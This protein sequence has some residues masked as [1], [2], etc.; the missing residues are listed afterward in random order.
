MSAGSRGQ[1][2]VIGVAL[3][4]GFV[5]VGTFAVVALGDAALT[6]TQ[7][8]SE[9]ARAEQSMTL[10]DSQAA[11][12]ALGDSD[13]QTVNLGRSDASYSIDSNA[14][15]ISI[16]QLDCD[17]NDTNDDGDDEAG[18]AP[19][20]DLTTDDDAYIMNPTSLGALIYNTDDGELAYQGGGVWRTSEGGGSVMVSPPEFHY[21][22]ATL[23]LPV[24]LTRGSGGGSGSV[25]TRI[26]S[27]TRAI[28]IFPDSA[29]G[30]PDRCWEDGEEPFQ[31]PISDGEVIV[32]IQSRYYEA[33][34]R[35]F[36]TRTDGQVTYDHDSEIV[37]VE[38]ISLGQVGQFQ[39][40][41][42]GGSVTVTGASG[43]HSTEEFTIMLRPDDS[44]AADFNNLQW[45]MYVEEGDQRLEVNLKKSGTGED[46]EGGT[47]G[48]TGVSADINIYYSEDGGD[49]F[50]AWHKDE[51]FHAQC[52]DFNGDGDY[53]IYLEADFVD[54]ED[55]DN[56]FEDYGEDSDPNLT[57]V[58]DSGLDNLVH[59][60][61]QGDDEPNDPGTLDGHGAGWEPKTFAIS[62]GDTE[63]SDR[64]INH[65][66]ANLPEEF[67]LTVDDKSSNTV[68]EDHSQG[69]LYTG[70]SD[71]YI[72]FLH[73]TENE[74]E[75]EV[76]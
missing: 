43:A 59:F 12:V 36:S 62:N 27:T 37:E 2:E 55:E 56:D 68:S 18:G 6:D 61:I 47:R 60:T 25:S 39:M 45:S 54:D 49:T 63:T 11:Q 66:F 65:Y 76:N 10:F 15:E 40:P 71:R 52:E 38:L 74:I 30:F 17:D 75:V 46:C 26:T 58:D 69:T 73:I 3:L 1:S 32:R 64:L 57:Y 14:G 9:S 51:A 41:G 13:V 33:W 72:T 29:E 21:R 50:E 16:I 4:L 28:R 44:D 5:I 24:V 42:D 23:T 53:E 8:N 31:N 67:E 48:S 70:G 22:G 34:G 7:S 19:T 35:Y 20:D